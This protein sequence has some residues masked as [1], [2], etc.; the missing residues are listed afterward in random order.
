[1]SASSQ[2]LQD[3][4]QRLA[5]VVGRFHLQRDP[6]AMPAE[7]FH[8]ARAPDRPASPRATLAPREVRRLT[9]AE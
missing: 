3:Q 7:P 4:A 5:E 1:M 2:S 8:E 9:A 6:Q